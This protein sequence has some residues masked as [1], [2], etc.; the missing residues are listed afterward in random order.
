MVGRSAF[1]SLQSS[2]G[3][4]A[5][6]T[7][8]LRELVFIGSTESQTPSPQRGAADITRPRWRLTTIGFAAS[9]LPGVATNSELWPSD[10][11]PIDIRY[12]MFTQLAAVFAGQRKERKT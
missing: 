7:R 2:E 6:A 5:C 12:S 4:R 3:G 8:A 1:R 9:S 10:V 11:Q